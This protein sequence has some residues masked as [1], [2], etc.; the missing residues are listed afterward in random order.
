[1]RRGRLRV[2]DKEEVPGSSPGSPTFAEGPASRGFSM[3]RAGRRHPPQQRSQIHHGHTGWP[4]RTGWR[5]SRPLWAPRRTRRSRA[6]TCSASA[7]RRARAGARRRSSSARRAAAA[8]RAV[9]Q[10]VRRGARDAGRLRC[11]RRR[12][13]ASCRMSTRM[14]RSRTSC[15]RS[16]R[17]SCGR[18]PAYASTEIRVA[19]R[20]P[21]A[22]R[23]AS[24]VAGASGRT[25]R[26]A[27][28]LASR[29]RRAGLRAILPDSTA[30][31]RLAPSSVRVLW[32]ELRPA[33]ARSRSACQRAITSGVS[34]ASLSCPKYGAMCRSY[35]PAYVRAGF[36]ASVRA[37]FGASVT[38]CALAPSPT[39]NRT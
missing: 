31:C 11:G 37:G 29:T 26:R 14:V 1:M 3:P 38:Q 2:A 22:W 35:S 17:A 34:A 23:R 18:S 9:A 20:A 28:R 16:A 39:R 7:A 33:P 10:R 12:A 27:G 21:L 36:G 5:P 13:C 4:V 8:K 15:H 32:I 19:S 30:R 6:R 24:T 25:S